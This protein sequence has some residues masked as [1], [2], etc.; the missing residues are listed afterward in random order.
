MENLKPKNTVLQWKND[1]NTTTDECLSPTFEDHILLTVL[2]PINAKLPAKVKELYGPRIERGK[3][4]MDLKADILSNVNNML[5]ELTEHDDSNINHVHAQDEDDHFQAAYMSSFRS[6]RGGRARGRG[7]YSSR[8]HTR[9]APKSS[10][11]SSQNKFCR[12]C[13]LT[14]QTNQV[15]LSHHIG[16][17]SCPSLSN[18]DKD[19][20]R[21]KFSINSV[22]HVSEKDE[23]DTMLRE[24]GYEQVQDKVPNTMSINNTV[25]P[26]VNINNIKPI[27]SQILTVYQDSVPQH[28]DLDSGCWVNTV[29]ESYVKHMK[30]NIYPNGQL[31]KIAYSKT[32]MHS[33][34]EIHETFQRNSWSVK[35]SA[36]IMADLH[37]DMIAGNNFI[38][39]NHIKQDLVS[40]TITVHNKYE[41]PETNRNTILPTLPINMIIPINVNQTLLPNQGISIQVPYEEGLKLLI[42]PMNNKIDKIIPQ[43]CTVQNKTVT[44]ENKHKD[45][46]QIKNKTKVQI[47]QTTSTNNYKPREHLNINAS[48]IN[49]NGIDDITIDKTRLNHDQ[50]QV[51]QDILVSNRCV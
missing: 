23:I 11:H 3:F 16:D 9:G 14:R 50:N 5:E 39:E 42:E 31:A 1:T 26:S 46:V 8:Q 34:G 19:D 15:I 48:V 29:K 36:I 41:V 43:M 32:V 51:L 4:L 45:P 49:H 10:S 22:E 21:S 40:K 24:R 18:R 37:T 17:L 35:F 38:L 25:Q 30:W 28:L 2:H 44:I 13:H 20:L 7:N 12:L 33:K 47:K 27:P 6:S